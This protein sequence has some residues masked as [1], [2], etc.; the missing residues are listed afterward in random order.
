MRT[1]ILLI[2]LFLCGNCTLKAQD[3]DIAHIEPDL[4]VRANAVIRFSNT[5]V[6]MRSPDNVI[7]ST[8][9]AITVFNKSGDLYAQL[10]LFYDKN[11]SIK[12]VKGEVYDEFGRQNAKFSLSN[13]KDESAVSSFSLFEDSRV[14]YYIPQVNSYPYTVVYHYET[15]QKQNLII[16]TWKPIPGFDISLE[17][18]NY[19]FI[20][21]PSDEVRTW[22]SMYP[23]KAIEVVTDKQKSLSWGLTNVK[24]V[25]YENYA[26]NPDTY[27][28]SVKVAPKN[29]TYYGFKGTY[30]DWEDL[31]KLSYDYLLKD[32]RVLPQETIDR[33]KSLIKDLPNDKAKAKKLYEYM[34]QKTRYISVQIGIGGFQPM[35]ASEVDRLGYGD[36]K[37]L[38]NYM[39]AL[40]DIAG[41]DSYYCVVSAGEEKS[42]LLPNFASMEQG[43]HV[44]LNLPLNGDTI[45]L[46]CTNQDA[47]FGYLGDF[48]DDR[49]VL[50]CTKDGGKLLK[51]PKTQATGNLQR[52]TGKFSVTKTGDLMGSSHTTFE[53]TQFDNHYFMYKQSPV[54]RQKSLKKIYDI[55]NLEFNAVDFEVDKDRPKFLEKLEIN[56]E[57]YVQVNDEKIYLVPNAFNQHGTV[58][59]IKNRN[60]PLD[61]KRGF[62]DL[63]S[64]EI[65]FEQ[66][67]VA[68][69]IPRVT[70]L[71]TKF[72]NYLMELRLKDNVLTYYR[73]FSLKEGIY[74]AEEYEAYQSFINEVAS[75]DRYKTVLTIKK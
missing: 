45:W 53:G 51:T 67:L 15:R 17:K 54:E 60:L 44:I 5:T 61:I 21:K 24:A 47:P 30:A 13:F 14:K 3:L 48:T 56:I 49:W 38:V 58:P 74:D 12:S 70:K 69:P 26:P 27:L 42:S 37:G 6:D 35:S 46:E 62:V 11:T 36:C 52:R 10:V 19:Q 43:N 2:V 68:I 9:R 29:F 75:N 41:I 32:K 64:L 8:T 34:Q 59:S 39:Q 23:E 7:I 57:K 22:T 31:G 65:T 20:C 25:K 55:N 73:K 40:L 16:P 28:T 71:D 50:A 72:G 4:R 33:I 66:N 1:L 63:D 18:A